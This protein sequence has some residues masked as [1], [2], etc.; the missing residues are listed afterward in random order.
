[1]PLL[2][3]LNS[4]QIEGVKTYKYITHGLTFIETNIFE[5][6]WNWIVTLLPSTLAPNLMTL[7]GL[8]FPFLSFLVIALNDWTLTAP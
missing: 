2:L 6:F 3:T 8:L 7:L 1:M 5:Y 4:K